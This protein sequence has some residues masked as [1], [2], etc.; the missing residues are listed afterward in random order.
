MKQ[1]AFD[2][3]IEL[4]PP[5]KPTGAML[6]AEAAAQREDDIARNRDRRIA[7]IDAARAYW[8]IGMVTSLPC[9]ATI[10]DSEQRYT[11]MLPGVVESISDDKA[12]VRIYADPDY[13]YT[14]EG[15][16]LHKKLAI[17][18]PLIELGKQANRELQD[19]V[20][21]GL[22]IAGDPDLGARVRARHVSRWLA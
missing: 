21:R 12:A 10:Q 20:D 15:Y 6:K 14:I 16:P 9:F 8:N 22:L 13:G 3:D 7:D 18:V 2:F 11:Q 5:R 19:I 4:A 1:F 17:N